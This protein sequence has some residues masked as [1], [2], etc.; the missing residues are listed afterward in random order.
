MS[1]G[2]TLNISN[3]SNSEIAQ[4][5]ADDIANLNNQDLVSFT[6]EQISHITLDAM[7]GLTGAQINILSS[8]PDLMGAFSPEQISHL[9]APVNGGAVDYSLMQNFMTYIAAILS[10]LRL[11]T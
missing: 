3:M 1:N 4:L 2:T 11:P 5:D 9:N 7:S 8:H 10:M 6:A